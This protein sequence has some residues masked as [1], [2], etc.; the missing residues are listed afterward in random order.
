MRIIHVFRAPLG[1]LFRHVLDLAREQIARG[2]EV[3]IFCD[4]TTG[5]PRTDAALSEL[6]PSLALGLKRLPIARNPGLNDLRAL[7]ALRD[8]CRALKPDVLHGHGS[9]GG[10]YA[11]MAGSLGG[12][13]RP[14]RV[15]TPHGGSFNYYPGSFTHRIYMAIERL[16]ARQTDLFMCESAFIA[17]RLTEAVGE[18]D[19][20]VRVVHNGIYEHETVPIARQADA[21]DLLYLGELR[22]AKGIDTL[23]ES[24]VIL[25]V[26]FGL[27]PRLLL[28]GSGPEEAALKQRVQVLGLGDQ[29]MF[30]GP[31][32]IR[33][34]L[35][36]ARIMAVPSRAES[37]PYVILEAAA[38]AQPL[39]ATHAGGIP[40]IFGPYADRLIPPDNADILAAS[41]ERALNAP[42]DALRHEASELALYVARNFTLRE[43]VDGVMQGYSEAIASR[44]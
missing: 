12:I 11:R 28:V 3:G 27:R 6:E 9:K 37:L 14:I 4:S 39:V 42:D 17:G 24:L 31:G 5:G 21:F 19:V 29:A 44:R 43:M 40:E 41:L 35:A 30:D 34:A 10:V 18:T 22:F 20:P 23:L 38:A 25:R 1:G 13:G 33:S 26:R 16:M 7:A 15:Y 8:H 36:R 32:P 2:H